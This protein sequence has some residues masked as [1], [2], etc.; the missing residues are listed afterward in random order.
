VLNRPPWLLSPHCTRLSRDIYKMRNRDLRPPNHEVFSAHRVFRHAGMD[1]RAI[2]VLELISESNL[3]KGHGRRLYHCHCGK[4]K[5]D[6]P[7]DPAKLLSEN[8]K[9]R[10]C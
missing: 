3:V 2:G 5:V 9:L 10:E 1:V 7:A 4:H 6:D 8:L